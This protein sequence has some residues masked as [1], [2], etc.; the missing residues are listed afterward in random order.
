LVAVKKYSLAQEK[1]EELTHLVRLKVTD[2]LEFGF[3]EW[4]K[5]QDGSAHGQDWQTWSAAMYLYAAKCVEE[6]HTPF[7]DE[8]RK[9]SQQAEIAKKQLLHKYD[10]YTNKEE[11]S[12]IVREESDGK[13][14]VLPGYP[15]YPP[16]EDIYSKAKQETEIDPEEVTRLKENEELRNGNIK[17]FEDDVTG[18]DLDIP[19]VELDDDAEIIGSED[20]EN[21]LYSLGGDNHD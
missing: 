9:Y 11:K 21:N 4:I 2:K 3:N 1:L 17:D 16:D 8:M 14:I 19:G 7:F 15:T 12:P 10:S 13:K 6:R 20:E 18:V 5:A